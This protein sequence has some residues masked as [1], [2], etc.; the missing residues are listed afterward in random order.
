MLPKEIIDIYKSEYANTK[1]SLEAFKA[2]YN[3][4]EEVAKELDIENWES[5]HKPKATKTKS[6]VID[7]T[8]STVPIVP[9]K[10]GAKPSFLETIKGNI[11]LPKDNPATEDVMGK[12]EQIENKV[13]DIAL[14]Y[15]KDTKFIDTK[16]LK[17]LLNVV[18]DIKK[19]RQPKSEGK[20]TQP[21]QVLIQNYIKGV[22]DDC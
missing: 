5:K 6:K 16:E 12:I 11:D 21:I 10:A 4:T 17:D 19:S 9:T 15:V 14:N 2:K 22:S 8:S 20:D 3:M 13:V 18:N 7:N 1:L